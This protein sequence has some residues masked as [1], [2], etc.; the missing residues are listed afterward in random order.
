MKTIHSIDQIIKAAQDRKLYIRWS[1]GPALDRRQGQSFDQVSGSYHSGLSAQAVRTDR[2]DMLAMMLQE[3][4]FL[5]RK[6]ARIYCWIFAGEQNG[7]DSDNAPTIDATTIEPIGRVADELIE[8]CAAY[9]TAYWAW[10]RTGWKAAL[11]PEVTALLDAVV[12]H[13]KRSEAAAIL[14]SAKSDRKTASSRANGKL[15]GRPTR[16]A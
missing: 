1:R 6:D 10:Q 5:R 7:V 9:N 11:E 13:G 14:G 2:L 12:T 16:R 8:K 3:Y 4:S 15:G